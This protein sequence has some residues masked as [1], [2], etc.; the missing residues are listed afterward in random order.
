MMPFSQA[1]LKEMKELDMQSETARGHA[2]S[3]LRMLLVLPLL[4]ADY[5]R[6]GLEV[7][8]KWALEKKVGRILRQSRRHSLTTF[9]S[10]R[11]LP[12]K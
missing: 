10:N 6:S 11:F 9:L 2:S 5:I 8:K 1:V 12:L 7:V 3:C 4:P